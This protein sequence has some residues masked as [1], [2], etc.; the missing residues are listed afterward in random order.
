MYPKRGR[1]FGGQETRLNRPDDELYYMT[2]CG[3]VF[4]LIKIYSG[5]SGD[6]LED[7]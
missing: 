3:L 4:Y 2:A 7:F 5:G 1:E 6:S